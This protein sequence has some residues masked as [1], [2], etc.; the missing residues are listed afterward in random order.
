MKS[1]W[2]K[3]SG[4]SNYGPF[5]FNIQDKQ[6]VGFDD[7]ASVSKKSDYILQNSYGGAAVWTL[8]LDDFN[9]VCCQGQYP[10]LSAISSK[11][12]GVGQASVGCGRPAPPVT[13]APARPETTTYDDG[14]S[15]G[16]WKDPL[17]SSSSST[18]PSSSTTTTV[19]TTAASTTRTTTATLST[20]TES[21]KLERQCVE[22]SYYVYPKDC[23]KYYF[24]GNGKLILQACSAGLY[25]S[26][27]D[28]MCD[29]SDKVSCDKDVA[30]TAPDD[31]TND[32]DN[33]EYK[34]YDYNTESDGCSEGEYSQSSTSCSSFYQCVNGQVQ[35]KQ[36]SEGLHWNSNSNTCDWPE[37]S[38]CPIARSETVAA[39][40]QEGDLSVDP[41]DCS[42]Y[43]FCVHGALEQFSCQSGTYWDSSLKVCNF[44]DQVDCNGAVAPPSTT[45]APHKPV[46]E[47]G[48]VLAVG[49][50][51]IDN[52]LDNNIETDPDQSGLSGD[53]KIVCYFTNWAWYRPGI[54]KYE[55][56]D[57]DPSL[58]THIVYGF[59]VLDYNTLT[60][61]PHDTWAD[62]DNSEN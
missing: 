37:F 49:D 58:C 23:Q 60:I 30:I 50:R 8:D 9:N 48:V 44:P 24:C 35:L 7:V 28:Q 26:S 40:C 62:L 15:N 2:R 53:Y 43:L 31:N 32:Y 29:W 51:N 3:N 6:W 57:V 61:K 19:T 47:T 17:A 56:G 39:S 22:G 16:G 52:D 1:G 13:P 45:S 34:E 11:L 38:N 12:R 42:K 46:H 41:E 54:G 33:Y 36:C 21:D 14:S 59:A 18:L 25:W 10:L 55:A 20:T 4:N 5:A 27:Q